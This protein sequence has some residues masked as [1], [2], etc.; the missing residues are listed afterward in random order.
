MDLSW[1]KCVFILLSK[2]LDDEVIQQRSDVLEVGHV[3]GGTENGV[4]T[5]GMKALNT[6]KS[7]ERTIRRWGLVR[8]DDEENISITH[9]GYLQP[10]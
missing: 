3:S 7:R 2:F 4:I 6:L 10:S 9:R 1:P 5:N 8:S